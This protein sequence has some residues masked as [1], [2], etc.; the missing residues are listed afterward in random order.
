[1]NK[2]GVAIAVFVAVF[3]ALVA[4]ST[5]HG[6]RYRVEIC[7]S[8]DG[9]STCRTVSGKSEEAAL[10]GG[11]TNACADL[12]SGVTE[13][14]RCEATKPQSVKWFQRPSATH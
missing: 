9:R 3:I 12:V 10:R 1:L 8:V 4:Y 7:M 5:F 6:P 13:T 2:V 14:M 11:M